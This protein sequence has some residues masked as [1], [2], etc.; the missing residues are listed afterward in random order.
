[1]SRS[2]SRSWVPSVAGLVALGVVLVVSW[3]T[4]FAPSRPLDVSLPPPPAPASREQIAT[5]CATC[6]VLPPP[7]VLP[8]SAW[9]AWVKEMYDIN[10]ASSLRVQMPPLE[11]VVAFFE[12]TAPEKLPPADLAPEPDR[13]WLRWEPRGA[14]LPDWPLDRPPVPGVA[15]VAVGS[16]LQRGKPDILVCD[17]HLGQVLAYSP[18]AAGAS[19]RV[20]GRL[21]APC[22]AAVVDLDED[23]RRDLLVADLGSFFPSNDKVGSVVWLRGAADGTF[24]AVAL[25]EGVG[26]V[27]D[28]AAA[29][30]DGDGKLDLAVAV[31]GWRIPGEVLLLLNR[32]TDWDRPEF[33]RRVLENR[34][35]A[36]HV[37]PADLDRD[38]RTDLVV[39][40]S[41]QHETVLA[42]LAKGDG[43]FD[44]QVV[45][46]APHPAFGSSG[47]QLVDLDGDGD[48]DVLLSSG[49]VL[50]PP[51]LLKPYHGVIWLEN[52]GR[53]PFETRV[54]SPMYGAMRAVAADFDGDGDQD[55]AATS[56]LPP[57]NYPRRREQGLDA[58]VLLEQTARG[59]F[60]RRS[61]AKGTCDHFTCDAG[62]LDGDGRVDLVT[63]NFAFSR[64]TPIDDWIE[65]WRNLGRVR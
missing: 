19:W 12:G 4:S 18:S 55:V 51:Y 50:D 56:Y 47:I 23:G 39:L 27:A 41:Q 31:F 43:T 65:V 10:R 7:D 22:H 54:L 1:M 29:D 13:P 59:Q 28:V 2:R 9:R 64:E 33:E 61:L 32:T 48:L 52:T 25:L 30:L 38:G 21:E 57:D 63:G 40:L 35:G 11:S 24:R 42:F 62:D 26:R 34:T 17:A 45:W 60:V 3:R 5:T 16:L 8:R 20:L 44:R 53:F 37:C 15:N 36:T 6:H 49:D 46:A 14:G 58:I